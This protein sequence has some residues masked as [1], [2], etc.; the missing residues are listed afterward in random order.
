MVLTVLGNQ[1]AIAQAVTIFTKVSL[2]I[3]QIPGPMFPFSQ[4][5]RDL[6]PHFHRKMG[7]W[8]PY[9]RGPQFHMT[10]VPL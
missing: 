8:G 1:S 3:P 4:E 6:S 9:Y 7:S 5:Y 10:L 2:Y